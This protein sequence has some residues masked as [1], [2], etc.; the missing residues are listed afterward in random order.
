MAEK[1]QTKKSQKSKLLIRAKFEKSVVDLH[2][3]IKNL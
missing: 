3:R 1:L 2:H